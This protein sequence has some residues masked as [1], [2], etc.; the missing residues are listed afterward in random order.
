M[1]GGSSEIDID[2]WKANTIYKGDYTEDH[3][4]IV[5][6]WKVL[7]EDPDLRRKIFKYATGYRMVPVGGMASLK[8]GFKFTISLPLKPTPGNFPQAATW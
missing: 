4:T 3:P 5:L 1:I 8:D 7:T 2:D 6:F